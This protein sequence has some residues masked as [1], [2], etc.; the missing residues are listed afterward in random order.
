MFGCGGVDLW[1]AGNNTTYGSGAPAFGYNGT[2]LALS[3]ALLCAGVL[4]PLCVTL[5]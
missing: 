2:Y 5:C 3:P 4:L 1:G